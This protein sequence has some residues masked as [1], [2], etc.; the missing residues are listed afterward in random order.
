[1]APLAIG[2]ALMVMVYMGGHYNPAVSLAAALRGALAGEEIVPCWIAQTLGAL[3]AALAVSFALGGT[4]A[5]APGA[6][7][8]AGQELLVEFLIHVRAV[9]GGAQHGDRE[10][11]RWGT[12]STGWPSASPSWSPPSRVVR[13]R[14]ARSIRPWGSARRS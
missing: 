12:P 14:A 9:P 10:E 7:V 5:P 6:D 1:M 13:S 2:A 4:F 8:G 3:V 11:S